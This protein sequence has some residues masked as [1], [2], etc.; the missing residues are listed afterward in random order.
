MHTTRARAI[1]IVNSN[2]H[3]RGA[4]A[5]GAHNVLSRGGP[6][7]WAATT[8]DCRTIHLSTANTRRAVPS[9]SLPLSPLRR[10]QSGR[11]ASGAVSPTRAA[12]CI[13]AVQNKE[14]W[15]SRERES[16]RETGTVARERKQLWPRVRVHAQPFALS[17]AMKVR[18][19]TRACR[20]KGDSLTLRA[21]TRP[22]N[23]TKWFVCFVVSRPV[24]LLQT[25]RNENIFQM[26]HEHEGYTFTC[27]ALQGAAMNDSV[28]R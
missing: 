6:I 13:Y 1:L 25:I 24:S 14:N 21:R 5:R 28:T 22:T 12:S 8:P 18:G 16:A 15:N 10:R 26:Q 17:A 2:P 4:G 11:S 27:G 3:L 7:C 9:S 20:L 19:R 23:F